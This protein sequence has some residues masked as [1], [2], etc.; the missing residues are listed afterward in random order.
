MLIE[1]SVTAHSMSELNKNSKKTSKKQHKT[2]QDKTS[3]LVPG[4]GITSRIIEIIFNKVCLGRACFSISQYKANI[5]LL[6]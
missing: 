1:I 4:D 5:A 6:L 3:E 2:K